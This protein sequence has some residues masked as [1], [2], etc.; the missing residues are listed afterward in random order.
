[1]TEQADQ[2]R[3]EFERK[4]KKSLKDY[5]NTMGVDFGHLGALEKTVGE[6]M[7]QGKA[8]FTPNK[9]GGGTLKTLVEDEK[10]KQKWVETKITDTDEAAFLLG[11][12]GKAKKK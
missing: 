6:G 8:S 3:K 11:L 7:R 12:Q 5:E 2:I 4:R 9:E 10:G 1:M